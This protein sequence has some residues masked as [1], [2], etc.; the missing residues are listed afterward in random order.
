MLTGQAAI[1]YASATGSRLYCFGSPID[2]A[3]EIPEDIACEIIQEDPSLVFAIDDIL[4]DVILLTRQGWEF[5][6]D[7]ESTSAFVDYHTSHRQ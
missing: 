6:Q 7:P 5:C 4:N 2:E 3:G 1:E